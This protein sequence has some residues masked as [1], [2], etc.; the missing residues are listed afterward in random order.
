MK[1]D[2]IGVAV[3]SLAQA[4]RVYED[5][6]LACEGEEIVEDQKVRAAFFPLGE[7]RVELLESTDPEG[8]IGRFLSKRGPGLHHLCLEVDDLDAALETLK[9]K[10]YALID[11]TP[12]MGAGGHRVAFVHP[13]AAGGV[14][15]EL[16]ERPVAREER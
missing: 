8:P 14:L 7:T 2:H 6:G 1:L 13:K 15:L 12:R 3:A 10:G 4:R 5:L 9:T 11:E 16:T